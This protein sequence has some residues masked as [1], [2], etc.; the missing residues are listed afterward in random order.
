MDLH[1]HM[2]KQH[3]KILDSFASKEE[4]GDRRRVLE[5]AIELLDAIND[6]DINEVLARALVLPK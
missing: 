1:T 5:K 4:Y 2:S 3:G 6:L